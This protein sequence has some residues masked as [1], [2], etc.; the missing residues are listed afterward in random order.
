MK[1]VLQTHL[2][3]APWLAKT[4]WRLPG[5]EPVPPDDWL[6]RD[7]AFTGQMA[8]RDHL[9]ETRAGDVHRVAPKAKAAAQE[10][11]ELALDALRTDP[12]YRFNG[13]AIHR[14]D[15]VVISIDRD[16]PLLTLG[17]LQQADICLMQAGPD[18]HVLTGAILC[19]PAQWT[20]DEKMGKPLTAIHRPVPAYSPDL[21]RRVQRL[22]DGL[23]PGQ[24]L[25]RGNA[26][27]YP[28]PD[29]FTPRSEDRAVPHRRIENARYVRSERQTL[30]RLPGADAVVFTIHT[31][32][33]AL[34]NLTQPQRETLGRLESGQTP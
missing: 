18:G 7:D 24:I 5:V 12:G 22:F 20:L 16:M 19:F 23:K 8:L 33:V 15:G 6:I 17:R 14:P 32:V 3:F 26:L 1:P 31:F 29:L 9:I 28:E 13:D 2:P 34:D 30:R 21:A 11:L 10:C 27:L 4:T 25:R